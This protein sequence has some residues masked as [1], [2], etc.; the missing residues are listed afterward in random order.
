MT[1]FHT[2]PSIIFLLLISLILS[3]HLYNVSADDD[4]EAGMLSL[5]LVTVM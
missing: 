3:S 5:S 2:N 4:S 1:P